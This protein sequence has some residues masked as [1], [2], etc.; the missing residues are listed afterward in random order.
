MDE[1]KTLDLWP[2]EITRESPVVA[3][4]TFTPAGT[5]LPPLVIR[6]QRYRANPDREYAEFYSV[7]GGESQM[8]IRKAAGPRVEWCGEDT[9]ATLSRYVHCFGVMVAALADGRVDRVPGY[10]QGFSGGGRRRQADFLS[11]G[12]FTLESEPNWNGGGARS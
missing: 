2:N 7:F 5:D 1:T 10:L 6:A 12:P 3:V 4:V 9:A 8:L 11:S